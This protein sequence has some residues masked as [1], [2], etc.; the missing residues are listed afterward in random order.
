[1]LNPRM[2]VVVFPF[3]ECRWHISLGRGQSTS[4][5][6]NLLSV[7]SRFK[8][9]PPPPH[10]TCAPLWLAGKVLV[11]TFFVVH[12]RSG[13]TFTLWIVEGYTRWDEGH[14]WAKWTL[15][16]VMV[17]ANPMYIIGIPVVSV[18]IL[19]RNVGPEG[20]SA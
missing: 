16:H 12:R 15:I 20:S 9:R 2:L 11:V 5:G 10:P 19:G 13:Q 18:H 3:L 1:M 17:V 8:K 7:H 6:G 14:S 4:L